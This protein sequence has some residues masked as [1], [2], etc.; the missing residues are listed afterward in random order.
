LIAKTQLATWAAIIG[1][2]N[3]A[4]IVRAHDAT[5]LSDHIVVT[6]RIETAKY[7]G[8]N[9]TTGT[10]ARNAANAL[11]VKQAMYAR[12]WGAS[13]L[14]LASTTGRYPPPH[15]EMDELEKTSTK[16]K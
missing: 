1:T 4:R 3:V 10:I 15:D 14:M 12:A 6:L 8:V 16:V 5:T 9:M 13:E 7:R 11:K 2:L